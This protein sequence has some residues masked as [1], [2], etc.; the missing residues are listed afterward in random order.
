MRDIGLEGEVAF[1]ERPWHAIE[2]AEQA[3]RGGHDRVV[4]VG[5]DGTMNQVA[6]GL[7]HA[8]GG[9]L[10]ILPLG[11]G[12][13]GARTLGIP[14]DWKEAV[15]I[16]L[17]GGRREVDMI[18]VGEHLVFNAIGLGLL[19]DISARAASVKLVRGLAAYLA[20]AVVSMFRFESPPVVLETPDS[21]YEGAMTFLAVHGGPTS[22]RGFTLAPRAIP[23]DGL[24]DATLVPGIGPLGR[25]P[26]L[27]A[28]MKGTLGSMEGTVEMQA[29]W[30][31]LCFDRP[32]PMH[33]DGDQAVL[34]PPFARFEVLPKAL[35]VAAPRQ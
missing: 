26:R 10:C 17:D 30:L 5:G 12:N 9:T 23:D 21:R 24:L 4:A 19:G 27:L 31:E 20:T 1:T 3:V 16:I 2:L 8:G 6:T 25:V 15:Q 13:D 29:P 28:A 35:R 14:F 22:G 34:E 32:L 11:T 18:R 7:C 33:V